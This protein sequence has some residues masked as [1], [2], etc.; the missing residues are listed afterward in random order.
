MPIDRGGR[1]AGVRR[2][3]LV[4]MAVVFVVPMAV[5]ASA[6]PAMAERPFEKFK[7]CP[8]EIPTLAECSYNVTS[9]G[10]FRIN[11]TKV[12]I[13]QS[14]VQQSGFIS[15]GD[16]EEPTLYVGVGAKAG[17]ESFQKV[18]LNVPGGLLG[19]INCTEITG[20]GFFEKAA[21]EAC[22]FVF[23][24]GPTEVTATTE[25]VANEKN[26]PLLDK[27]NLNGET[28][29][30]VVL[31]VRIH[32]KNTFLGNGCYIGSEAHPVQLNLS[33]GTSGALTGKRGTASTIKEEIPGEGP[34]RALHLANNSLV[35][36]TF[37]VPVAE[38]CGEFLGIK[39][40]LNGIINGKIGLPSASGNNA[41]KLEGELNSTAASE[42]IRAGF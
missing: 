25:P 19:F 27:A 6:S 39:G 42:V 16:P 12:P 31:P 32:L 40:F 18:A 41:A 1:F 36:G 38:G 13:N 37:A 17:F 35:D 10:E 15:A 30:A 33:T 8:T 23:E 29:T 2:R 26:P 21:R 5:F 20:E 22:K 7:G 3:V 4:M 14:I 34:V 9:A 28:G 11:K 24:H